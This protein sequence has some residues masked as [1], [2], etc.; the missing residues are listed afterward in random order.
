MTRRSRSHAAK[1]DRLASY[2]SLAGVPRKDLAEIATWAD[3]V[4][5]AAGEAVSGLAGSARWSYLVADPSV[6]VLEDGQT[7]SA[8]LTIGLVQAMRT[9][10]TEPTQL[11]A[12]ESLRVLA[13]PLNRL[14]K[15]LEQ[16]PRLLRIAFDQTAPT[17]SEP[18]LATQA[19]AC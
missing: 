3:E 6:T 16:A 19:A 17:Q 13:I 18:L 5:V 9:D 4:T 10:P 2:P 7:R 12:C 15:L 8:G 11:I 14:A 1:I